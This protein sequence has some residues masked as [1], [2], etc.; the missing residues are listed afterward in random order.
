MGLSLNIQLDSIRNYINEQHQG[1][2]Y[3]A[4]S[5]IQ[6]LDR[7]A[8]TIVDQIIE[9]W[10]VDTSTSRDSFG[11]TINSDETVGFTITNDVD[12]VE[13][14]VAKGDHSVENGGTP[15]I[16]I[17]PERVFDANKPGMLQDLRD[18]VDETERTYSDE[19]RAL[20]DAAKARKAK[21]EANRA[22]R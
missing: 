11:F 3:L 13:F 1:F 20:E 10:P 12:Y 6:T 9:A 8:T 22:S 18:A 4:L 14:I 2:R 21:K 17:I 19:Q 15:I 7:W 5:E 16:D